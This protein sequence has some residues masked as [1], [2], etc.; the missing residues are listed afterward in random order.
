MGERR[1]SGLAMSSTM[2]ETR[3]AGL[4]L[5]VQSE[6]RLM[7]RLAPVS[8]AYMT[9][10]SSCV[11]PT[12]IVRAV[13]QD[14]HT[15]CTEP[16]RARSADRVAAGEPTEPNHLCA[17]LSDIAA[18]Y[19]HQC[20]AAAYRHII[21]LEAYVAHAVAVV[22]CARH[23]FD[24]ARTAHL[25]ELGDWWPYYGDEPTTSAAPAAPCGADGH[26]ALRH[27]ATVTLGALQ[28]FLARCARADEL[29]DDSI[30]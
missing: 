30:E 13:A 22:A 9:G 24:A 23:G 8:P 7:L 2:P 26:N 18:H 6:S 20:V 5:M 15:R 14:L 19:E 4:F 21:V 27:G 1:L 25:N 17:Q 12:R 11:S 29:A 3:L 16:D 10:R 28:A